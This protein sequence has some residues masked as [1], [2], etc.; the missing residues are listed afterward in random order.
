MVVIMNNNHEPPLNEFTQKIESLAKQL[1]IT[2]QFSEQEM[3]H[4]KN[5]LL[6]LLLLRTE[7]ET[8][9]TKCCQ[10]T[11][12]SEYVWNDIATLESLDKRLKAIGA[13]IAQHI[14][15]AT[16]HNRVEVK[17]EHW[18]WFF[19]PP[20]D[21]WDK[22]DWV[23]NSLTILVLAL[24]ASFTI[25]IYSSLS[26]G[27][28]SQIITT[29]STVIQGLG[30]AVI[31]GGAL[32]SSGQSKIREILKYFKVSPKFHAETSFLIAVI[33]LLIVFNVNNYLKHDFVREG[34]N[35]YLQ[36]ELNSAAKAYEKALAIAPNRTDISGRLGQIYESLGN[37]E[38]AVKHYTKSVNDGNYE[39]LNALGRVFTNRL[40][41]AARKID[42]DLA[43]S[44]LLIGLQRVE[45]EQ[46]ALERLIA[47]KQRRAS[48][49][50][51]E[52]EALDRK[53]A[54][55]EQALNGF[56]LS[57]KI[58]NTAQTLPKLQKLLLAKYELLYQYYTNIGLA[59]AMK[60]KQ[61]EYEE[62]Q[63]RLQYAIQYG[64]LAKQL[65]VTIGEKRRPNGFAYCV[66]AYTEENLL[67]QHTN[68]VN[69]QVSEANPQT[70]NIEKLWHQCTCNMTAE[71][72]HAIKWFFQVGRADIAYKIDTSYVVAGMR[73]GNQGST[74]HYQPLECR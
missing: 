55:L 32:S 8:H 60:S 1:D 70:A 46:Q 15:L 2:E 31:G 22:Y 37:L 40:D 21:K 62:A 52:I 48:T 61:P 45:R 12:F 35:H 27:A 4:G 30:L 11:Q 19:Q 5:A 57:A 59:T 73:N 23:W 17:P 14:D 63:K 41:P 65:A 10:Q 68:T 29:F 67:K 13:K 69:A 39:D 56:Q 38:Q 28:S 71:F 74:Y 47:I 43:R 42:Y 53:I 72:I 7:I 16:W 50:T 51:A 25:S 33:F 54:K 26:I 3:A 20:I 64:D 6:E 66:L 9:L 24:S 49:D 36:G 58:L 18:W 44:Y 34:E